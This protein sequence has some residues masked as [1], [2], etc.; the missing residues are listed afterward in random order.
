MQPSPIIQVLSRYSQ[1]FHPVVPFSAGKDRLVKMDFTAENTTLSTAITEDPQRFASYIQQQLD[2]TGSRYGIGG[3]AE[4]RTIYAWSPHFDTAGEPRRLH[5]G[6]DIWGPAGTPV[7][8]FMGGLLHSVAFNN[9]P[10]DYGATLILTHQLDAFRFHTLYGHISLPDIDKFNAGA[11]VI[12]GQEIAHFGQPEENGHW[13][14]HLHFQIIIEM[15]TKEGD[16]PGVCK[17]SEREKYLE[18]CPD[19]DLILQMNQYIR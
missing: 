6:V 9:V 8:A 11:Y 17:Y 1:N 2:N 14:P 13:P 18:N 12:R 15:G 4:H 16:Y 5:L 3:Y 10:G 7:Y 19:P